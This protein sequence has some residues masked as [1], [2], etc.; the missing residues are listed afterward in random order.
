MGKQAA[1]L[2]HAHRNDN[3]PALERNTA[4]H[5]SRTRTRTPSCLAVWH[6][7]RPRNRRQHP[8]MPGHGSNYS[9]LAALAIAD[10][11]LRQHQFDAFRRLAI[12]R[13][14]R[15][16]WPGP[17]VAPRAPTKVRTSEL[18][19]P[20]DHATELGS[21]LL[22]ESTPAARHTAHALPRAHL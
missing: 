19:L 21:D 9:G 8:I 5:T 18:P 4:P 20:L 22:G 15:R 14:Y 12:R 3:R 6:L 10:A 13:R 16:A 7:R 1:K 11:G 17:F 2:P